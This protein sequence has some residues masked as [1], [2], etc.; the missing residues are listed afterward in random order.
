MSKTLPLILFFIFVAGASK[1]VSDTLQFHYSRSIFASSQ[2]QQWWNPEVSWKNKYRDY[3]NGDTREAYLFSRSLLVWRT[4]AW[5]LAQTI[6]TLGW[7]FALLLAIR[8]GQ[9]QGVSAPGRVGA[10][11]K[12]RSVRAASWLGLCMLMLAAFYG[13]F[14]LLWAWLLVG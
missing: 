4:D 11:Y 3:D 2:N 6:E 12:Q 9:M 10:A 7:I 13:G 1:G 5:H 14:M 8:L